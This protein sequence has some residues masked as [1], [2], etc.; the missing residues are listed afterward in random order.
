MFQ[1]F[2]L[3]AP[4]VGKCVAFVEHSPAFLSWWGVTSRAFHPEPFGR[5]SVDNQPRAISPHVRADSLPSRFHIVTLFWLLVGLPNGVQPFAVAVRFEDF[6]QLAVIEV[7]A[8]VVAVPV[9]EPAL[10]D[11][12]GPISIQQLQG[13]GILGPAVIASVVC[14]LQS[15]MIRFAI[16]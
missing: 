14:V 4:V 2:R 11:G 7:Q 5:G 9:M 16:R 10:G 1:G 13:L 8:L 12:P 3:I 15:I 6:D